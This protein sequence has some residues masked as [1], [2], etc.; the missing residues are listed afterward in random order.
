M[1]ILVVD[2][3]AHTR[4]ALGEALAASG[5][6]WEIR[7]AA[8]ARDGLALAKAPDVRCVVLDYQLPGRDGLSILTEL[9][10]TRPELAVVM[11]TGYGSETVAVDAMK[12]GADDYVPKVGAY[13]RGVPGAVR[14]ALARRALA[15]LAADAASAAT[16][17]RDLPLPDA[18]TRARFESDGFIVRSPAM[19]RIVA[20][21]VRAA[22]SA[23]GNVLI[24]GESGTG[25]EL[26]ARAIHTQG[27]RAARPFVA[28]NCAALPESLLESELFG[29]VRGAFTGADRDRQGLFEQAAGGTV[30]LDEIGE[31]TPTTQAKLLR[32][33]QE[34]E[35]RP[36]GATATRRIDVRV[37]SATNRPLRQQKDTGDF[38]LD[39]YYRLSDYPIFLPALRERREDIAPLAEHFLARIASRPRRSPAWRAW[40]GRATCATWRRR[41][42][43]WC[44]MRNRARRSAPRRSVRPLPRRTSS[45]Q[46]PRRRSRRSCGWSSRS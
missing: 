34:R 20:V 23:R 10:R 18:A 29:H 17:A 22:G 41:C 12:L 5:D 14:E 15:Q 42:A 43:G 9:Q 30:F 13:A 31:M 3:D 35:V 21:L 37:V 24:Q 8:T 45:D 11:V 39:L 6:G 28:V 26:C 46:L 25:K 27:P 1:A 38:R 36:L 40:T 44:C 33:L 32:V 7:F 19:L 2:D 16:L 4:D